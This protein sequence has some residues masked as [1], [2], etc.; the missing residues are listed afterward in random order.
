MDVQ[1][2]LLAVNDGGRIN[3]REAFYAKLQGLVKNHKGVTVLTAA[4]K[5]IIEPVL[6]ARKAAESKDVAKVVTD[7]LPAKPAKPALKGG[8]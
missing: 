8:K 7:K 5:E 3:G 2:F 6:D 4:G 1:K